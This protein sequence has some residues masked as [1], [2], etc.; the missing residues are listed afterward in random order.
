MNLE[1]GIEQEET[2]FGDEMQEDI[3]SDS[4]EDVEYEE[5]PEYAEEYEEEED[6]EEEQEQ[7]QEQ[8]DDQEDLSQYK[9]IIDLL[10]RDDELRD[11]MTYRSYG[12]TTDQIVDGLFLKRHPELHDIIRN[13]YANQGTQYYTADSEEDEQ[14]PEFETY[15]EEVRYYAKKE[16]DRA[17]KKI[18]SELGPKVQEL[19]NKQQQIEQQS[20]MAYI[21]NV[22]NNALENA[23]SELGMSGEDLSQEDIKS[24]AKNL[25]TL[26]PGVDFKSVIMTPEQARIVLSASLGSKQKRSGSTKQLVKQQLLPK[27]QPTGRTV[28]GQ[29]STREVI[30]GLS[31]SERLKRLMDL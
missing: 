5:V 7:E 12:Y 30:D 31:K 26:Y 20:R 22:N 15:E 9:P 18:L 11:I 27:I 1:Y 25:K 10:G 8:E 19:L 17:L 23:L 13:Y 28:K 16:A 4:D 3:A 29:Q 2:L 21:Y 24:I 14:P 6:V